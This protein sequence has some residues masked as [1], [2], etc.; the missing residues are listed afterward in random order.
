MIAGVAAESTF[1][2]SANSSISQGKSAGLS[3]V[4]P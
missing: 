2:E 3:L 1:S 4:L